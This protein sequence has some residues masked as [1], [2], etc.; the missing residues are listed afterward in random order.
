VPVAE[1]VVRCV[2]FVAFA[3]VV[4]A[5]AAALAGRVSLQARTPPATT[6]MIATAATMATVRFRHRPIPGLLSPDEVNPSG[7]RL[8]LS[9]TVKAYLFTD[10][11]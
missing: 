9:T 8:N 10:F 2:V 11:P 5:V 6:T 1:T 7:P 4:V 3:V